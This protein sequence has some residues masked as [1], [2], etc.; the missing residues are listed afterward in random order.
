MQRHSINIR[1][2]P[3]SSK[4]L[5]PLHHLFQSIYP[6]THLAKHLYIL[7][8]TC[9]IS[10]SL[11]SNAQNPPPSQHH[12]HPTDRPNS[13]AAP[14]PPRNPNKPLLPNPNPPP[15]FPPS[16]PPPPHPQHKPTPP[17]PLVPPILL[18]PSRGGQVLCGYW[19][20]CFWG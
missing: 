16:A 15:A 17:R 8:G 9:P 20:Y 6:R 18:F 10:P 3:L 13:P 19:D 11:L 14:T 12:H 1:I 5:P 7:S 4:S 2:T